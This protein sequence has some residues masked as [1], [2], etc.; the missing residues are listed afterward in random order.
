MSQET[1]CWTERFGN[2]HLTEPQIQ[3]QLPQQ[4]KRNSRFSHPTLAK[5]ITGEAF[6]TQTSGMI[7][8]LHDVVGAVLERGNP[9]S[10]ER[11][12]EFGPRH[13]RDARSP[14]LR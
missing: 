12:Q 13:T 8:F 4:G 2:H 14:L 1:D 6:A 7:R 3:Q 10:A 5:T 9:E 11:V